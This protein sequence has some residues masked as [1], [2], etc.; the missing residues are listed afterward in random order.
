MHPFPKAHLSYS[1]GRAW[2]M[3]RAAEEAED[4]RKEQG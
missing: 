4:N 2:Q 1:G 3:V